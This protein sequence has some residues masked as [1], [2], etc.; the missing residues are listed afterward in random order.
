MQKTQIYENNKL[1]Y[2]GYIENNKYNGYG[3]LY[4]SNGNINIEGIWKDGEIKTTY[5]KYYED[6]KVLYTSYKYLDEDIIYENNK[7][8]MEESIEIESDNID[9]Y[10]DL[11]NEDIN[12]MFNDINSNNICNY[13]CYSSTSETDES[14][15]TDSL[16][17]NDLNKKNNNTFT[18]SIKY[19]CERLI[20]YIYRFLNF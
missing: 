19:M 10:V 11:L 9:N 8:K 12:E 6:G 14:T 15:L 1:L 16:L 13:D 5:K 4:Y 17:N 2:D 20:D 7:N 18:K 3:I